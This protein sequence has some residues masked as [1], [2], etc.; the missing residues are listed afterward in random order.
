MGVITRAIRGKEG[1]GVLVC[2]LCI[3]DSSH[4][5]GNLNI[6]SCYVMFVPLSISYCDESMNQLMDTWSI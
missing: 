2:V 6:S 5:L 1:D 4:D 3:L